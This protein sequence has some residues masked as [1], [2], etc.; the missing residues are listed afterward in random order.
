M[1]KL[2]TIIVYF[3]V[4]LLLCSCVE[5]PANL[6]NQETEPTITSTVPRENSFTQSNN[7]ADNAESVAPTDEIVQKERGSLKTIRSQLSLDLQKTHKNLSLAYARVSEAEAMPTYDIE[8][9]MNPDFTMDELL[10][11]MYGDRYDLENESYYL[12]HS[13]GDPIS[14]EYPARTEPEYSEDG[15]NIWLRNVY[16]MDFDGFAP[17]YRKDPTLYVYMYS[18]G[19]IFGSEC[20]GGIGNGNDWFSYSGREICKQYYLMNEQPSPDEAYTMVD[21]NEWNVLESIKFV[22]TFWNDYITPSDTYNF[23][24]SVKALYVVKIDDSHFAYLFEV[25]KQDEAGNYYDVDKTDFYFSNKEILDGIPFPYTNRLVTY[26]AEKESISRFGKDFSFRLSDKTNDGDNLLALG[27]AAE[28]LSEALAPNISLNLTAELNYMVVCKGYHCADGWIKKD[29]Y[30][31]LC[32]RDSDFEI[33]PYWCF[34]P[35]GQCFLMNELEAERYYVDAVT[36]DVSTVTRGMY[37]K[38]EQSTGGR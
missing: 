18:T 13:I 38:Y 34:K 24:Y 30:S 9:G 28:L 29:F 33:R 27:T 10:K 31:D 12:H 35:V 6:K 26:C 8:I 37:Q 19:T 23:T 32:L 4:V 17:N 11:R 16:D 36:G 1:K 2:I 7:Y 22:E 3:V 14:A 20:G 5:T 25:Q 21:G 15:K